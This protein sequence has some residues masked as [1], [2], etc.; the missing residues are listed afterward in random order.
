MIAYALFRDDFRI[1]VR[2]RTSSNV[3]AMFRGHRQ[4]IRGIVQL[5]NGHVASRSFGD[6]RV[7]NPDTGAE[8]AFVHVPT[9]SVTEMTPGELLLHHDDGSIRV[10]NLGTGRMREVPG[11]FERLFV[12]DEERLILVSG[13]RV[14]GWNT[15]FSDAPSV[16]IADATASDRVADVTILRDG[17]AVAV[18]ESNTLCVFDQRLVRTLDRVD[19]ARRIVESGA[20]QNNLLSQ[21]CGWDA[22][23]VGPVVCLRSASRTLGWCSGGS[24][25][26]LLSAFEDGTV[27][28]LADRIRL[29]EAHAGSRRSRLVGEGFPCGE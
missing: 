27:V 19:I 16:L 7:W 5:R 22:S 1:R 23:V 20:V 12:L 17:R 14:C 10:W 3:V 25:P 29:L 21:G 9:R 6:V 8:I 13:G 2:S 4:A 18:L 28:V 26:R 24:T 15:G 11:G